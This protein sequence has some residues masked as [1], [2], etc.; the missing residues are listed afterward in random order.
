MRLLRSLPAPSEQRQPRNSSLPVA[1]T[2]HLLRLHHSYVY[3]M[4][5]AQVANATAIWGAEAR[6]THHLNDMERTPGP[7]D[8]R[9]PEARRRSVAGRQFQNEDRP[10]RPIGQVKVATVFPDNAVGEG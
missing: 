1:H 5:R 6:Q 2:V 4:R 9:N 8:F 3:A 7:S 10:F